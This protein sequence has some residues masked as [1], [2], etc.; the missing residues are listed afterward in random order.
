[1]LLGSDIACAINT[2][3]VVIPKPVTQRTAGIGEVAY[4][5]RC[6][7]T[8]PT[9]SNGSAPR[10]LGTSVV[11][12]FAALNKASTA[13]VAAPAVTGKERTKGMGNV[14]DTVDRDRKYRQ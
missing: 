7:S 9:S 3:K 11:V 5:N 13:G 8:V 6:L 10:R 4:A 12:G 14:R 2:E 1:M